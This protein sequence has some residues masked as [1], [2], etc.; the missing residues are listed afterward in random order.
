M[1]GVNA[2]NTTSGRFAQSILV[3]RVSASVV[4]T[5]VLFAL[6]FTCIFTVV[7]QGADT[8]IMYAFVARTPFPDFLS[9]MLHTLVS[10]PALLVVAAIILLTIV[11]RG[12]FA[13]LFRVS[14]VLVLSN[15]STQ[16]LKTVLVR[17]NL[18]VGHPLANSFPSG[19]VTLVASI[20]LVLVAS[21][22]PAWKT[23]VGVLGW[24]VTAAVGIVVMGLGWHRFSDVVGAILIA[25]I[26]AML[27]LP[28]EWDPHRSHHQGRTVAAFAWVCLLASA[29]AIPFLLWG[30]RA[31]LV[32]PQ[33]ASTLQN[34]AGL[35]T[36][37]A[38][39][40]LSGSVFVAALC[41]LGVH[42][43]DHLRGN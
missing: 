30:S 15:A 9:T 28:S 33:T 24:A 41:A 29:C 3:R 17:P 31:V 19:H 18:G 26:F 21:V 2:R 22:P 13:L 4:A 36:L 6:G 5:L 7:G 14:L 25:L 40:V 34:L 12:R 43:V 39:L 35:P 20:A 32:S 23:L 10:I 38:G 8:L 11:V 1:V 16:I 37:G 42:E 27:A